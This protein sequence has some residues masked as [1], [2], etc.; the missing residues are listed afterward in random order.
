MKLFSKRHFYFVKPLD[1]ITHVENGG[2][3]GGAGDQI[4]I[5]GNVCG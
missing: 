4:A 5:R 1:L 2:K 3:D